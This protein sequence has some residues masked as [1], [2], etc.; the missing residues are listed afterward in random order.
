M[1]SWEHTLTIDETPT[2][3]R[4]TDEITI[5]AGW[6]T[7]FVAFMAKR[8]YGKRDG[9]RRRLLGLPPR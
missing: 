1:K 8:M 7:P 6:L 5:D 9:V 3:A 4:Q 2:G